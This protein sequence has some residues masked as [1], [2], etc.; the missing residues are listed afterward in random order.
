MAQSEHAAVVE[1][2]N[3]I[4]ATI[5]GEVR[6]DRLTR[7]TYATDASIYEIVPDGVVFPR[8]AADVAATVR[9]CAQHGVPVTPRGGGTGL[10]GAAVNRG[11]QLDT[12]RFLNRILDVDP[13]RRIARVE[14]GV[15]LDELNEALKEHG[16]HFA[17]D[18]ATA[19]RANVGGMIGNNSCGAHSVM[20]GRTCD[21]LA[22]VEVVLA[23][24]SRAVWG[25][26]ESPTDN[27]FA[28][29][30]ADTVRGVLGELSGEI[31]E[32]YPKV[33]RRNGGYALDRLT[34]NGRLNLEQLICGS[35]GTLGVIVAATVRLV[36]LPG[37]RG[38]VVAHFDDLFDALG[39]TPRILEHQPAAVELVDRMILDAT[40]ANPAMNRRRHFID[41][42]PAAILVCELYDD[43]PDALTRRL[44]AL[45]DDLKA[46]GLGY[47]HPI[48]QDAT[49]QEDVWYIRKAGLGLLTSKPGDRQSHAFVEDSAVE[50]A[51][52]RDY[53]LRFDAILDEEGVKERGYYAHASVGCIH[54]R[55][56]LNLKRGDD[57]QRMFRVADR[58]STLAQEF[59]GTMTGEH[60][61]GI[62][63]SVWLEK[64]YGPR[65]IDGFRKIK[66]AFDPG[67]ILNPGKIVDPLPMTSN[68][69][70]GAGFESRDYATLLDF[71]THGGMAGLAG[72]CSGVGQCRQRLVGT[73][74]PSYMATGD[75]THTTRAR[76]NALRIALSNRDLLDGLDDP[77]LEEVFDLCLSCKACKTEC[78]T[79]TDVAKLK[80]EWQAYQHR[81]RGVP[82]RSRLIAD[83]VDLAGWGS[84][85]A[86]LSNW[87][88]Q[89]GLVRGIMERRY[90]L[91]RRIP[92]P[93]FV[94][95]TFRKWFAR[96]RKRVAHQ[97]KPKVALFV[98]TWTNHYAPEQGIASVRVLEALGFHVIVPATVCCGRPMI[99]KGLLPE[100]KL[101][102]ETNARVLGALNDQGIPIVGIEP[103][104]VSALTDELPQF[105]RTPR[106]RR[107]AADTH[108]VEN[109]VAAE[110]A[111][112]PDALT[113]D[114]GKLPAVLYHGHCHQK[115]LYGTAG[116]LGLLKSA[117]GDRAGEINSG[118]CG[119]AGAFG[120]EVEHYDVAQA[121]GEQRLF[122]A[123]R[124]RGEATI[125]ISGFSCRHQIHHHTG[126]ATRHVM[127]LL[128][129]ALV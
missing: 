116:A 73:M 47:A 102:A 122:P 95:R 26:G 99:S 100:A 25:E 66:T 22:G 55:P 10:T 104:C 76:A 38:M 123:V 87:V 83:A 3:E 77:A 106:A 71:S 20:F 52:L 97:G 61:D 27:P 5:T 12:S 120:H 96:H 33:M 103:S 125:A 51:R 17:P 23:D 54:A 35:E 46:A 108:L 31:S 49:A 79:G 94:R 112:Q 6:S 37:H 114:A 75:E 81:R 59:G 107:I 13:E 50:P 69:R 21:H 7:A 84:M 109:W 34:A 44:H 8:T 124:A 48:I 30:C 42:A 36:P 78:P 45:A 121:V 40:R 113:L 29:R 118:C 16:L 4:A 32:R 91:D 70:Y 115:A 126:A 19:S 80:A 110:L 117:T 129:D 111:E 92:P 68:L 85:F 74:C 82:K 14:P 89:S 9:I 18:V 88:M 119:M 43:D 63:R 105:V 39:A 93:Q 60:G 101:L 15:V 24:G 90:G 57:V 128:A 41:D 127:E 64:M 65:I 67:G 56:V 11:V 58:V 1:V 86:P 72:M 53:L 2:L 62:V 28:Q 98:D